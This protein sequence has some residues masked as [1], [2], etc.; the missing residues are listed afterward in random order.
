MLQSYFVGKFSFFSTV[1]YV[2]PLYCI[3]I[4]GLPS[5]T[6]NKDLC[7]EWRTHRSCWYEIPTQES[8]DTIFAYV[9][10][11]RSEKCAR[12]FVKT[13]HNNTL[14]QNTYKLKCQI[15]YE[16]V[17]VGETT[18]AGTNQIK[19]D[20]MLSS[21][22]TDTGDEAGETYNLNRAIV[23][24]TFFVLAEIGAEHKTTGT[25]SVELIVPNTTT[26]TPSIDPEHGNLSACFTR[27]NWMESIFFTES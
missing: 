12:Q 27:E 7:K 19:C 13:W 22:N 5:T 2:D 10:D 14:F 8:G 16:R 3:R 26:A 4:D 6:T 11:Q 23:R 9:R 1:R 21:V 25:P 18:T 20:D 15:E 17:H 24:Q